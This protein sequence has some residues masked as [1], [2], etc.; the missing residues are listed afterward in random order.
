MTAQLKL[1][2]FTITIC[3]FA[4]S[5]YAEHKHH[6]SYGTHGMALVAIDNQL[7]ASHMPLHNSMHEH[8]IIFTATVDEKYTEKV[9]ILL[10]NSQLISLLPEKFDLEKLQNGQLKQFNATVFQGHFERGGKP[11]LPDVT[12]NMVTLI[13]QRDL[14]SDNKENTN[15][16]YELINISPK[17]WLAIHQINQSQSFD[18]LVWLTQSGSRLKGKI[19]TQKGQRLS[20]F[21]DILGF[22]FHQDLYF[23]SQDFQ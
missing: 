17:N 8:Q 6:N 10:K 3:L 16:H 5:I 20:Q 22:D 21:T 23:E 1:I 14:S 18:H 4:P 19:T 7:I 11:V 2:F 13:Y 12:F 15:G 9:E